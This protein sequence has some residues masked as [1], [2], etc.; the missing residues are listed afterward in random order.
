MIRIDTTLTPRTLLPHVGRTFE[1]A[2]EKIALL[3]KRW[4]PHR[5]SPVFTVRGAYTSRGWT[6]W[7]QGFFF[8]LPILQFDGTGERRFLE[9]GRRGTVAHMDE[10]LTH[11]GV[12]DH[13]FNIVSTYGNLYRLMAEGRI[14]HD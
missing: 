5:G 12:H 4:D 3:H 14:G 6:E 13:G 8:G 2:E 1:L 11:M 7:T 10:H 9:L